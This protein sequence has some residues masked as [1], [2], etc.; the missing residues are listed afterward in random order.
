MFN[1]KKI[2]I[3]AEIGNNHEGNYSLAKK[4][5]KQA[6]KAGANAV[7]F[8]TFIPESYVLS[9]D[10]KRIQQ[11]KKFQLSIKQFKNLSVYANKLK[12][13]FF[14]TPFDI[15]SAKKLNE[16]QSIFKISSGDNNFFK[17]IETVASF[18]K[19]LIISTGFADLKLVQKIYSKVMS[20]WKQKKANN[21]LAFL[22]CVSSYP[23]DLKDSNIGA[24]LTLKKTFKDC[25]IGY[26]DHTIGCKA[27]TYSAILGAKIIE[28][29][30]TL[31]KNYSKFRDHKI[32]ADPLEFKNL[33]KNVRELPKILGDGLVK[34]E[35][36]EKKN[37][38][39]VRR[40][41]IINKNILKNN[42]IF[43]KDI[44]WVR[45][46]T[47]IN[48]GNEKKII[49]RKVKKNLNKNELIKFKNLL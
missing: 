31:N 9:S 29:H 44:N 33:V 42:K 13:I 48:P 28:K 16:F 12:L 46:A 39:L 4:L 11:L 8:Q 21:K 38:K 2:F 17:L 24:I 18:N 36:S 1:N 15:E 37:I 34:L 22:H 49:G 40:S 6:A 10:K 45:P 5:I 14:S 7:K 30:F 43:E 19:P 23:V 27:A 26:S 41:I 47:G 35:E 3:V 25:I 32:S 20:I